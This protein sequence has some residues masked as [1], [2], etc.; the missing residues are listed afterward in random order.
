MYLKDFFLLC[1]LP[2]PSV[3]VLRKHGWTDTDQR[4]W[5]FQSDFEPSDY[6]RR[7]QDSSAWD[8]AYALMFGCGDTLPRIDD[9]IDVFRDGEQRRL[10]IVRMIRS[11]RGFK[12]ACLVTAPGSL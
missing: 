2:F 11:T 9:E 10:T 4:H 5:L 1:M 12:W 8:D 6:V 3:T 7:W